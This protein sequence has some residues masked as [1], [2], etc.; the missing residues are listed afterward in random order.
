MPLDIHTGLK[1]TLHYGSS[2]GAVG[3]LG[4][5]KTWGP[6]G[7]TSIRKKLTACPTDEETEWQFWDSDKKISV[8]LGNNI[9]V[10]KN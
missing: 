5:R 3:A 6:T 4:G 8:N 1:K 10:Y 7:L 9:E 2:L